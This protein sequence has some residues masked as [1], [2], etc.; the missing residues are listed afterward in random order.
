M[1]GGLRRAGLDA[2]VPTLLVCA[3]VTPSL[4]LRSELE[5]RLGEPVHWARTVPSALRRLRGGRIDR[6][7]LTAPGTGSEGFVEALRRLHPDVP[8]V[9][10]ESIAVAKAPSPA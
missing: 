2:P 10:A 9:S 5:R 7:V 6:V 8:I 3:A 1:Q 4:R